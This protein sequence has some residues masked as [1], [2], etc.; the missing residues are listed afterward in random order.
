MRRS[1]KLL[2]CIIFVNFIKIFHRV[3]K[4]GSQIKKNISD[5]MNLVI[6]LGQHLFKQVQL[7]IVFDIEN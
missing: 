6:L 3:I 1:Y 7:K 5:I 4:W 2:I